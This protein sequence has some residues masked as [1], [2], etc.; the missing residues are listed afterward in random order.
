MDPQHEDCP[1]LVGDKPFRELNSRV[2]Q[3]LLRRLNSEPLLSDYTFYRSVDADLDGVTP[4]LSP[5]AQCLAST[6]Y[7]GRRFTDAK[8][9]NGNGQVMFCSHGSALP[10][11]YGQ[12]Q[13]IFSHQRRLNSGEL[14][15]QVFLAIAQYHTLSF[16]DAHLDPYRRFDGL[17]A[18]L[19]YSVPSADVQ[20]VPIEAIVSHIVTCPF[21]DERF[22]RSGRRYSVIIKLDEVSSSI[23]SINIQC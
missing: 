17:G 7:L 20:V 4:A 9:S 5:Y 18:K 2:Y 19:V 13:S 15:L 21:E 14:R 23:P 6:V 1:T 22:T 8:H 12:I 16:G 11:S 3:G 10:R